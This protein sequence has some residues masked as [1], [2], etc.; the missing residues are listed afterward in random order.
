[1]GK[2]PKRTRIGERRICIFCGGPKLG[3][4]MSKEHL[5]SDWMND[6]F[7]QLGL[8]E[9][10]VEV[11]EQ[12]QQNNRP[13]GE[14]TQ[15]RRSGG[16]H[17][18]KIRVVCEDCNSQWMSGMEMAVRPYLEPMML[19]KPMLLDPVAQQLL[20]EWIALKVIVLEHDPTVGKPATPIF[21]RAVREQFV[22]DRRALQGCKVWLG[23]NRPGNI[24][25]GS[26]Q[27]FSGGIAAS[28]IQLTSDQLA[29]RTKGCPN[30]QSVTWGAGHALI[31]VIATSDNDVHR[32]LG[33]D[34]R[35]LLVPLW[36]PNGQPLHWPGATPLL[37]DQQIAGIARTLPDL[38]RSGEPLRL[39]AHGIV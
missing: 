16:T 8:G 36:P 14:V 9:Q 22:A 3:R 37:T 30:I 10:R 28:H 39:N 17:T 11:L 29:A 24:W 2:K 5:W 25:M 26:L 32:D 31:Y 38:T 1:M 19:G 34:T 7:E 33:W 21:A 18:K 20:A 23:R 15:W 35:G 12:F 27:R 4:K 6:I 13:F